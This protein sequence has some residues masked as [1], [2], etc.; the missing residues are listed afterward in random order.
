MKANVNYNKSEILKRAWVYFKANK[1]ETFSECLKES[2]HIA[3]NGIN[4]KTYNEVYNKNYNRIKNYIRSKITYLDIA[5][6]LTQEVFIKLYQHFN[7]Y[8]VNKA[9][10]TTWLFTITNHVIIDYYRTDK[11]N[12]YSNVENFVSEDGKETFQITAPA[13]FDTNKILDNK[14]LSNKLMSAFATLKPKYRRVAELFFLEE[15]QYNEIAEICNIPMGTVKGYISRARIM[16][17]ECLNNV[18]VH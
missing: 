7:E 13:N 16:L 18:Y 3:K 11:S 5:E 10:L 14:E 8:D 9:K 4:N 12:N 6:N 1:F 15:K 2:W 17:Q